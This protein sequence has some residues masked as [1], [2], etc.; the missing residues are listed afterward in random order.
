MGLAVTVNHSTYLTDDQIDA[1]ILPV[2]IVTSD[3]SATETVVRYTWVMFCDR[4]YVAT[5]YSLRIRNEMI[6]S[7][8]ATQA[9]ASYVVRVPLGSV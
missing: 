7:G 5:V 6:E 8:S 3:P 2:R 4:R 9:F 1:L